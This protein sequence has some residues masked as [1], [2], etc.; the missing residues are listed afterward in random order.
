MSKN[1]TILCVADSA[2]RLAYIA[3]TV[4]KLDYTVHITYTPDQAVAVAANPAS[5]I[6]AIVI[7]E[8]VVID[9]FAVAQSLKMVSS[10]P[11]LLVCDKG[12]EDETKPREVDSMTVNGSRQEIAAGLEKLLKRS[13]GAAQGKP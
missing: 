1:Q 2:T 11:I 6:D 12:M 10:A 4:K 5:H 3:R 7:D 9:G 13:T 8:D